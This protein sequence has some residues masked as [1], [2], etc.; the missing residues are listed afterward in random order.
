MNTTSQGIGGQQDC[1]KVLLAL[2]EGVA[3][4]NKSAFARLYGLTHSKLLGVALRIL[5]D[6]AL[7]ETCCR[8]PI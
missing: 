2:V 7:A 1:K 8:K 3:G 4:G 6:R 5:R